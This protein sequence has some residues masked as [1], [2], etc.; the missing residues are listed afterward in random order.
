MAGE[1]ENNISLKM[2][3]ALNHGRPG[4]VAEKSSS[5][6]YKVNDAAMIAYRAVENVN[7]KSAMIAAFDH[8]R[9]KAGGSLT[10]E[11]AYRKAEEFNWTVNDV[12]GKANR[13]IL[14]YHT[15]PR[16]AAMIMN[17]LQSFNIGTV[18]RS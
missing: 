17:S 10:K 2:K 13:P 8:F 14:A 16:S 11:E 9:S 7:T 6:L 4:S 1:R 3:W 18:G 15:M 12:G 5:L